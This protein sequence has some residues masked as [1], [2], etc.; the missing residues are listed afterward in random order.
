MK[1]RTA[2]PR[3]ASPGRMLTALSLSLGVAL[4]SAG[5]V[6]DT[7]ANGTTDPAAGTTAPATPPGTAANTDANAELPAEFQSI[8]TDEAVAT[9]VAAKIDESNADAEF[10]KLLK[11]IEAE[12]EDDG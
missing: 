2:A 9:E 7:P 4:L 6:E 12:E 3:R 11:E 10:D 5:C 1:N 8:P